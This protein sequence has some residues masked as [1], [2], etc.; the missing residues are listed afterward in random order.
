MEGALAANSLSASEKTEYQLNPRTYIFN[1]IGGG[2]D[3][4][5]KIDYQFEAGPGFGLE[6]LKLTN[7]VWKGEMGFNFQ[8]QNRADNTTQNTYSVRIAEIFAWRVWEKLTADLKV[9][10]FPNLDE[11]GEYRLRIESTLRY[12]V[13]NRLSL[14]LDVIDLYD[15]RP[16]Q[17]VS[18]NDLQIRSTI[19]VTF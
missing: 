7:F 9:E 1:L 17:D 2:Y 16:P 6:L 12:P 4:I 14:N 3:E 5:R 11:F 19:G 13:S 15:T 8:Q 10:F 18:Q